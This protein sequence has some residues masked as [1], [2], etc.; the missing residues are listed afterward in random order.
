MTHALLPGSPAI[1]HG[2]N[3]FDAPYDQRVIDETTSDY[4]YERVVGSSADIGAFETGAPDH[5]FVDGFDGE[6]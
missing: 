2:N 5:I 6:L 3:L 1:D 4:G